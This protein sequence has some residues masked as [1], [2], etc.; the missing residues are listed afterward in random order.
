MAY[1]AVISLK[2]TINGLLKP[3]R[4]F[5]T[6]SSTPEILKSA[7]SQTT[8]LQ[9]TLDRLNDSSRSRSRSKSSYERLEALDGQIR[10]AVRKLEDVFWN[11]MNSI[12]KMS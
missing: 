11:S 3:Y 8:S 5:H 9:K 1:A 7:Y 10:D 4:N 12:L 2:Q 6:N